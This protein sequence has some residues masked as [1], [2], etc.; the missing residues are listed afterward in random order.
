MAL[1]QLSELLSFTQI[2]D[3]LG[4]LYFQT[5]SSKT[6]FC[7]AKFQGISSENMAKD[8]VLTYLD[9]R[10][11][12]FPVKKENSKPPEDL[13]PNAQMGL[14]ENGVFPIIAI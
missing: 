8:M 2:Y 3:D 7:R 4:L 5:N 1:F 11:L 12:N 9:S 14:S 13:H 10:V 6:Y